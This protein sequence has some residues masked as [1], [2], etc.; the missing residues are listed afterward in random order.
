MVSLGRGGVTGWFRVEEEDSDGGKIVNRL[1][2]AGT[3]R[4]EGLF[5]V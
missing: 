3:G 2:G 1:M 5:L 4:D